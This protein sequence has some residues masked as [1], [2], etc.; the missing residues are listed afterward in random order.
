ME[1]NHNELNQSDFMDVAFEPLTKLQHLNLK[2]RI[3][4]PKRKVRIMHGKRII[5]E[6]IN[7]NFIRRFKY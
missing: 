1:F 6:D 4:N 2:Q 3:V 7:N 5:K